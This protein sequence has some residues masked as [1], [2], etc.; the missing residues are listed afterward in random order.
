MGETMRYVMNTMIVLLASCS[1][2]NSGDGLPFMTRLP[3]SLHASRFVTELSGRLQ[4]SIYLEGEQKCPTAV[5]LKTNKIAMPSVTIESERK[6][7]H[8]LV[9]TCAQGQ[10][11]YLARSEHSIDPG[12]YTIDI[13]GL[14]NPVGRIA[15][16][17]DVAE[18]LSGA[19]KIVEG[20]TKLAD[21]VNQGSINSSKADGTDWWS[22]E[23]KAL[24][25][26]SLVLEHDADAPAMKAVL[27]SKSGARPTAVATLSMDRPLYRKMEGVYYIQVKGSEYTGAINYSLS[28]QKGDTP[29]EA[30]EKK[31]QSQSIDVRDL[32]HLD[33]TKT[34][35]LLDAGTGGGLKES[36]TV[37]IFH[38]KDQTFIGA[39]IVMGASDKEA[40]CHL[41][42]IL[43][44][45]S[46][47][48]ARRSL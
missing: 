3:E 29:A 15:F 38:S 1:H 5:Q 23:V 7:I 35:I 16:A 41:D 44:L 13:G 2:I 40:E 36:A 26:Y 18:K 14:S 27:Y 33:H 47:L 31:V 28:L 12:R 42:M 39:C 46:Q 22:F 4:L 24:T 43:P 9:V 45:N 20:G 48:I 32:W 21:G 25:S 11:F 34:A 6:V 8:K 17:P 10:S 19:D 37:K 30:A